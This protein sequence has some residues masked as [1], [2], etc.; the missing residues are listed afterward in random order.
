V[1][2]EKIPTGSVQK[3]RMIEMKTT[4]VVVM[5]GATMEALMTMM[6]TML[7]VILAQKLVSTS[8]SI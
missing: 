4:G 5:V 8:H 3:T 2:D 1:A 6:M 7:L